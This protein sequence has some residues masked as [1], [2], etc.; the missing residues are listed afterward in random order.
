MATTD[1]S[2]LIVPARPYSIPLACAHTRLVAQIGG[3]DPSAC[4]AIALGVEEAVARF[5]GLADDATA[6]LE[7]ICQPESTRLILRLRNQG[8]PLDFSRRPEYDPARSEAHRAS[9]AICCFC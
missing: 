7:L 5:I 3:F 2:R 9:C 4:S 6:M 8:S 1:L